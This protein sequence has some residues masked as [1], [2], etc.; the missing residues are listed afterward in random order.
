MNTIFRQIIYIHPT[1]CL[2]E[3]KKYIDTKSN[4]STSLSFALRFS[5]V[6][7]FSCIAIERSRLRLHPLVREPNYLYTQPNTKEY[8]YQWACTATVKHVQFSPIENR[9]PNIYCVILVVSLILNYFLIVYITTS[10]VQSQR[11][12]IN[13]LTNLNY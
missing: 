7:W 5:F 10:I 8:G 2:R 3:A 4:I 13:N 9:L 6:D 11:P 12:T 1:Y